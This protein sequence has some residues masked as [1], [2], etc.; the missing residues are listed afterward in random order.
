MTTAA[1]LLIIGAIFGFV[2][3]AS[4]SVLILGY[5]FLR[6]LARGLAKLAGKS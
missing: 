6:G 2:A 3:I 4:V 1:G 5:W